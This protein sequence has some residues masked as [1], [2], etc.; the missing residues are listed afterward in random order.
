MERISVEIIGY[1]GAFM[2]TA[3]FF[4]QTW[5]VIRT[6]DTRS[7]SLAM[8]VLFTGGICFWLVYGTM[9]E[10][11][12][13]VIANAITLVLSSMILFMKIKEVKVGDATGL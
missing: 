1:I 5:K 8:Y 6:R 9:I 4:P 3:A 10:S 7:I 12:P 2:T 11:I 13:V